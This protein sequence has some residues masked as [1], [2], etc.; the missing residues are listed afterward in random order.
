MSPAQKW[1]S[2]MDPSAC[3]ILWGHMCGGKLNCQMDGSAGLRRHPRAANFI[4]WNPAHDHQLYTRVCIQIINMSF[5]RRDTASGR[6]ERLEGATP[7]R[8]LG[9]GENLGWF[10]EIMFEKEILTCTPRHLHPGQVCVRCK[11]RRFAP[12]NDIYMLFCIYTQA[13]QE[14]SFRNFSTIGLNWVAC[15]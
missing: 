1:K 9:A 8:W 10:P 7:P 14:S 4:S 15:D 13:L 3:R 5:S 2:L 6:C 11:C 12:Q